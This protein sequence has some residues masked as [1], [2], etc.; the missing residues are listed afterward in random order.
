MDGRRVIVSSLTN[1]VMRIYPRIKH[2]LRISAICSFL[3]IGCCCIEKREVL[4]P[5][6]RGGYCFV[7]NF[8]GLGQLFKTSGNTT[9]DGWHYGE[10]ASLVQRF[11]V[12]PD[13]Y[14]YND[15]TGPNAYFTPQISNNQY[16]DGQIAIGL[17]L[18]QKEFASSPTNSGLSIAIIMA[19]EFGHCVDAKYNAFPQRSYRKELFA[20][21]LAGCY[22]YIKSLA[23]GQQ[24]IQEVA[25][26]F[27]I[28]G[29]YDFNN[30]DF[31]GTPE[32]RAGCLMAGYNFL[33]RRVETGQ[34]GTLNDCMTSGYNYVMQL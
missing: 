10:Y 24:Y 20:D 7:S 26:A 19:H 17:N 11:G 12:M 5:Q 32:Q 8:G 3:L 2:P 30:P 9:L 23:V 31:H 13:I 14:F 16:P 6:S 21:Y 4:P 1:L 29:N 27:Y 33:R 28:R 18:I 22:L 34:S 25:N 15:N